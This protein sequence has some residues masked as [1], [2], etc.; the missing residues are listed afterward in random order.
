VLERVP[1]VVGFHRH[2]LR[3]VLQCVA[4]CCGVLQRVTV[5]VHSHKLRAVL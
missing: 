4:A 5:G 2:K 1:L 3:A